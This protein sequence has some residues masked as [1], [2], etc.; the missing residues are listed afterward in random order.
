M[1]GKVRVPAFLWNTETDFFE[2][3]GHGL[4][5]IFGRHVREEPVNLFRVQVAFLDDFGKRFD[6]GVLDDVGVE[7]FY[8]LLDRHDRASANF[9]VRET[10]PASEGAVGVFLGAGI[11]AHR[12]FV[13]VGSDVDPVDAEAG[14]GGIRAILDEY[15]A[16]RV[17]EHPA[18]EVFFEGEFG[19]A[20]EIVGLL[21]GFSG[22]A[23][24]AQDDGAG[25]GTAGYGVGE[26]AGA[27]GEPG[28]FERR[29]A[30][31]T[32]A[33][34]GDDFAR[35]AAEFAVDHDTVVGHE[36][37]GDG[38]AGGEA[39]DVFELEIFVGEFANGFGGELGVGVANVAGFWIYGVVAGLDAVAAQ[40]DFPGARRF[41][42]RHAEHGF[43]GV[44]VHRFERQKG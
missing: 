9:I 6:D 33:G 5:K 41:F 43:H 39:G 42:A 15:R 10:R 2:S 7:K 19:A 13:G 3:V 8:V 21:F 12:H 44:V 16:S 27:N 36:L 32:N 40:G 26:F 38:G 25:F 24:V 4:A 28:V 17:G 37:V 23:G 18:E 31:G 14:A 34:G 1:G 11:H 30:S 29:G 20:F 35:S 22:V